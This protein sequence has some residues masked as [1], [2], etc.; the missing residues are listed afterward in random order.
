MGKTKKVRCQHCKKVNVVDVEKELGEH[1]ETGYK[2]VGRHR[3]R[4]SEV[5]YI[6][7]TCIHCGKEFK[8]PER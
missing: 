6:I 2:M 4:D 7:I 5:E 3:K 1:E 8:I